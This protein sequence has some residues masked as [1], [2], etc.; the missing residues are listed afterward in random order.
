MKRKRNDVPYLPR[1]APVSY[2]VYPYLAGVS[3]RDFHLDGPACAHAF[4]EGG[5]RCRELFGEHA[6]ISAC[7]CP[8]L[9]YGHLACLGAEIL[10]PENGAPW[11]TPIYASLDEGIRALKAEYDFARNA[12]FKQ[13]LAMCDY[14]RAA[15][16]AENV[17]FSGF[18][19]EGI[20]TSA[21]LLRGQDFYLDILDDP[22]RAKQ[23]LDL[24]IDSI[25]QFDY[26]C[27]GLN[28]DPPISASA[29]ICDDFAAL[30]P[31]PLWPEFVL[32][33]WDAYYCATSNGTRH[34]HCE[35][36]S[37][38]HLPYLTTLGLSS[39]DPDLSPKLT[40]GIVAASVDI[41]FGWSLQSFDY[42]SMTHADIERWVSEA[43]GAG[44]AS[45]YSY[46]YVNMCQGDIPSKVRSFM[47]AA[48]RYFV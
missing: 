36:L 31:P 48:K 29:M 15:F 13:Q 11:P 1:F 17:Q 12:Q 28:G 14:L 39:F 9:S 20:I 46:I 42:A 10:F 32:P 30:I 43:V 4:R 41:P 6:G 27:R 21:V 26:F 16:P 5:R 34:L 8:P 38:M 47:S 7:S 24:L 23:F 35:G 2:E 44:A 25:V 45:I 19:K 40:P 22:P 18:G 3:L 37:A 33:Y